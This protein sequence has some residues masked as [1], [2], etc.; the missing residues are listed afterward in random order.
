MWGSQCRKHLPD[1]IPCGLSLKECAIV[2]HLKNNIPARQNNTSRG[3]DIW[4]IVSER[5]CIFF[6]LAEEQ[7]ST[8]KLI[9]LKLEKQTK[10]RLWKAGMPRLNQFKNATDFLLSFRETFSRLRVCDAQ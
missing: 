3:I 10:T 8:Q 4:Y 1:E 5:N 6:S 2:S 7:N 9:C